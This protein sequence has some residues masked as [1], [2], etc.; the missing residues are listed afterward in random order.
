MRRWRLFA[1]GSG[2]LFALYLFF[3]S[4]IEPLEVILGAGLAVV[5]ALAGWAA[6]AAMR[7]PWDPRSLVSRDLVRLPLAVAVGTVDYV[8]LLVS[9][10]TGRSSRSR[11]VWVDLPAT[12]SPDS[13]RS[14]TVRAVWLLTTSLAPG[15]YVVHADP[16]QGALLHR[17]DG[18]SS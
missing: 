18:G 15:R 14:A 5:A 16:D 2:A 3:I 6:V 4:T 12:T 10:S 13:P 7:A 1:L 17:I 11:F 8:R 9:R